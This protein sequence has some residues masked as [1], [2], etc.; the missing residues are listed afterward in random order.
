MCAFHCAFKPSF[1]FLAH[2]VVSVTEG[3]QCL[4]LKSY[5]TLYFSPREWNDMG[6]LGYD[7]PWLKVYLAKKQ[8]RTHEPN[9]HKE[10]EK[11]REPRTGKKNGGGVWK[12]REM[13]LDNRSATTTMPDHIVTLCLITLRDVRSSMKL[14]QH[15]YYNNHQYRNTTHAY[16]HSAYNVGKCCSEKTEFR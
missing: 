10:Q 6:T 14:V 16:T 4:F 7:S 9:V 8:K 11:V 12:E 13:E 5:N 3:V 2:I 1:I 15:V